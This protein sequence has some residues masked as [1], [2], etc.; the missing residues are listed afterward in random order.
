MDPEQK[1]F[2][3]RAEVAA[4]FDV[5]PTTI[6]RWGREG[7]LPCVRTLGGQRR[8][9]REDV[10][11]LAEGLTPLPSQPDQRPPGGQ[12]PKGSRPAR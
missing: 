3:S 8:Y 12:A 7:K 5:S 11:S 2:L 6:T 4:I 9:R 10:L 1:R